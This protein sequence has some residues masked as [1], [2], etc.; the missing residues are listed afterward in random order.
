MKPSFGRGLTP[1]DDRLGAP[2]RVAV[3]SHALWRRVFNDDQSL[4]GQ[5]IRINSNPYTLIG[6]A[7][8]GFVGPLVGVATDVWVPTALQPE[9]DPPSAAVRRSRGRSA[10][11][12]LRRSRGLSLVGRL[13][14]GASIDQVASR[15]EVV[16]SRLQATSPDTNLNRRFTLA[17]LGEARPPRRDATDASA[18]YGCGVDGAPGRL[19]EC[20][21]AAPVASGVARAGGR[22]ADRDRREP[23]QAGSSMAHRIRAS[24]APG[25]DRG[26]I[27]HSRECPA[28]PQLRHSGSC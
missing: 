14:G 11:F 6:V 8:P 9:V 2:V 25:L 7:P 15:A 4:I 1:D 20:R 3:I 24:W 5:T 22:R 21:G 12:D 10:V 28:A 27:R 18:A 23:G 17:P 19:R 13:P 16:S 26:G